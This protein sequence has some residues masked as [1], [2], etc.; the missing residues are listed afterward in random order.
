MIKLLP[1]KIPDVKI[2][3]PQIFRDDRG[4]FFESFNQNNFNELLGED[5]SF[6]QDNHSKSSYGVL[7][8]LHYQKYPYE[9]GKLIRV[10]SGMIWDVAVDIRPE[11]SSYGQWVGEYL[12]SDDH[13]QLWIP[14]GFAHGFLVLSN[15][16]EICYKTDQFYNPD[17]EL[18]IKFNDKEL[19]I[20]WPKINGNPILS[21]KDSLGIGFNS[22][23]SNFE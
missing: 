19:N 14:K 4:F 21:N 10:V 22:L 12:S 3:Q 18:S 5:V 16:A 7:R 11:S 1:T 6:V 15:Y 9:Q 17:F 23:K 13:K 8:G 2:I 20:K